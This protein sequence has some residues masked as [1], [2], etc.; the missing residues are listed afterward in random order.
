MVIHCG[1]RVINLSA[2]EIAERLSSRSK[3]GDALPRGFQKV[4]YLEVIHPEVEDG[5]VQEAPVPDPEFTL[6]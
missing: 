4:D 6:D 3:A 1:K 2:K 5:G